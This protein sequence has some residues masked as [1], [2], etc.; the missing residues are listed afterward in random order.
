MNGLESFEM[1]TS[2]PWG[3][4]TPPFCLESYLS[5]K[6]NITDSNKQ[7]TLVDVEPQLFAFDMSLYMY[8]FFKPSIYSHMD[9]DDGDIVKSLVKSIASSQAVN[10]TV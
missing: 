3:F 10:Y 2:I 8:T 7:S 4:P 5:H 9:R 1:D 6:I